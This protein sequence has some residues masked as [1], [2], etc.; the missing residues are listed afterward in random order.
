MSE[1][2]IV[3]NKLSQINLI[4]DYIF[5]NEF[6][7]FDTETTGLGKNAKVIGFSVSAHTDIGYYVV[8][9][10]WNKDTQTLEA[11]ETTSAALEVLALLKNK[12]LV[13]HNA[14]FDC[15][16]IN[17]NFKID[18]M[19][20]VHTDT[21]L[22]AHLLDENRSIGLKELAVSLYGEE[23]KLEQSEMKASITLN[24]GTVTKSNYELYKADSDL[25][26]RY[27]AKDTILTLKLF[28]TLTPQLFEQNLD[29]FFYEEETM[30]LLRTATYDLNTIGLRVDPEKLQ[31]LKNYLEAEN[32]EIL[33]YITTE[34][35]PLIAEAY[36]GTSKAKTFNVGSCQQ[37]SWLLFD[38][39]GNPFDLLTD[40]GKTLCKFFG[41]KIPYSFAAKRDF[42]NRC[43]AQKGE[44]WVPESTDLVTG[45]KSRQ[46]VIGDYW[47][48]L[49]CG[50]ETL[51]KLSPKYKWVAKYLEL[52][53]NRKLLS[54]YVENIQ[55]KLDFNI[56]HPEFRQSGT[57]SGRYSSRNPNFQNLPR[58]DKRVKAC[59]ISRPGKVFVGA[60]YS[61]L[62]PRVFASFSNDTRLLSCFASGDDFYSVIGME[63]FNKY[64]C[65]LKKDD[66]DSFAKKYPALRNIS[67]AIALAATYGTTAPKMAA[68]LHKKMDEAQEIIDNYFESFPS[69][70]KLMLESHEQVKE[71]GQVVNL[72]GRPR[73]IPKAL[74]IKEI[75]GSVPHEQL[76]YEARNILNLSVNHRIQST[77]ASIVNRASITFCND[78]KTLKLKDC[79]IVLQCH[80]EIVVE[81]LEEDADDVVLLLKNAMEHSVEL[82]GVSL[83]AEPKI[84][85]NLAELK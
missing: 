17:S 62:E 53:K 58:D 77:A 16:M 15:K 12:S 80:D 59:I 68:V 64:D 83:D 78:V 6:I 67:K 71:T 37:L 73:R 28:Y 27:G 66:K 63:V 46:K 20:Y 72:F 9:D 19:P 25:I 75:F 55:E 7:A 14:L 18:L 32:A 45:K 31:D 35:A 5:E 74:E 36:P 1:K 44:V 13:M 2:L 56:I 76:P 29:K 41:M 33:N 8:L 60:D 51:S 50:K 26:A 57:T 40:Q 54:T 48:Y 81:C 52:A 22:L 42:I 30:P 21:M 4:K 69:V 38:K 39:L 23:S 49:T 24:G 10:S 3:I 70:R 82:P 79:H 11:L 43:V 61:Q 34:I 65:T 47:T 84:G 85:R